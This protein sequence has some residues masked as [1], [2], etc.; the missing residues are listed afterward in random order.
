MMTSS[1][2][3]SL[4][5]AS[6]SAGEEPQINRPVDA[7]PT[8]NRAIAPPA[9]TLGAMHLRRQRM[10]LNLLL[11]GRSARQHRDNRL[12]EAAPG[13]PDR[14]QRCFRAVAED[15]PV[16]LRV[17]AVDKGAPLVRVKRVIVMRARVNAQADV[18]ARAQPAPQRQHE[19]AHC[20]RSAVPVASA[21]LYVQNQRLDARARTRL[22]DE[23]RFLLNAQALRHAPGMELKARAVTCR[24]PAVNALPP[25]DGH[26]A[27][28]E[29]AHPVHAV[30]DL[31]PDLTDFR[32]F[33]PRIA[34]QLGNAA[35]GDCRAL[36]VPERHFAI[37][38][39]LGVRRGLRAKRGNKLDKARVEPALEPALLY[40]HPVVGS[41]RIGEMHEQG[42]VEDVA[43]IG[44]V[45]A[46][47]AADI[48][49]RVMR[50][51]NGD[52]AFASVV[53]FWYKG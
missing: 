18:E 14:R 50:L 10:R 41:A 1:A 16:S 12:V 33:L 52:G 2:K 21:A 49:Q 38:G 48:A 53:G 34:Q 27:A 40:P 47:S 30:S 26:V 13:R 39:R 22:Y 17:D 19:G 5:A 43:D 44:V 45:D 23:P 25:R 46:G 36:P 9:Q 7:V 31:D 51:G 11:D 4:G 32:R 42:V 35:L 15:L 37:V 29:A 24:H 20:L 6:G 28:V 3:F 8:G